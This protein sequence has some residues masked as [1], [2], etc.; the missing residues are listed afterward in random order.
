MNLCRCY[1]N[2]ISGLFSPPFAGKSFDTC[3]K[4]VT[5]SNRYTSEL[6]A[7]LLY[8]QWGSLGLLRIMRK[9]I[10]YFA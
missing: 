2:G 4:A 10:F 3:G 7:D 5:K 9:L 8:F 6:L 1:K